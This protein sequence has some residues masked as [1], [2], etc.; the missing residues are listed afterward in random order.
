MGDGTEGI[1]GWRR[2]AKREVRRSDLQLVLDM[3]PHIYEINPKHHMLRQIVREIRKNHITSCSEN[4][5]VEALKVINDQVGFL[6]KDDAYYATSEA[7]QQ[8]GPTAWY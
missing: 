6:A 3:L 7:A 4:S 8:G 2:P 5:I 1:F